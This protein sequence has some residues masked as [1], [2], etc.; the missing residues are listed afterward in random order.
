MDYLI[1]LADQSLILAIKNSRNGESWLDWPKELKDRRSGY[2]KR[3]ESELSEEVGFYCFQQYLF[4]KQWKKLKAYANKKGQYYGENVEAVLDRLPTAKILKED[5]GIYTLQA[6]VF[7][8]GV[9]MWF[10]SQGDLIKVL[11]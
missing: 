10:R 8:D 4:E 3:A 1:Y 6:E 11:L 5:D 9:D 2:V 7:G